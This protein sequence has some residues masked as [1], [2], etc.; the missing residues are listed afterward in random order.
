MEQSDSGKSV[1]KALVAAFN[2]KDVDAVMAL[3][4]VDAVYHN[5]PMVPVTGLAAIRGVIEMFTAPAEEIDWRI[6][7]IAENASVVF[8][9]RLDRFI[10]NGKTVDLP[11]TGVFDLEGGK[12]RQW[13]DYFDLQTW[14]RQTQGDA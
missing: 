3:F 6:I 12:I 10:I 5:M 8:A 4:T 1:I 9:E 14:R 13:R 11:C 2:R 7:E